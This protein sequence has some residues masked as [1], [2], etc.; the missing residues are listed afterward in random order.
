MRGKFTPHSLPHFNTLSGEIMT[1]SRMKKLLFLVGLWCVPVV[2][3][4]MI[5]PVA[6]AEGS[7]P[8]KAITK[9]VPADA[10]AAVIVSPTKWLNSPM[11]EMFPLEVMRVQMA[12]QVG[13][14]P[15]DIQESK[16]VV[17]LDNATMQPAFGSMTTLA[18]EIDFELVRNAVN[19]RQEMIQVDGY[20]TYPVDGPPGTV[21]AMINEQTLFYGTASLIR[22]MLDAEEETGKLPSLLQTMSGDAA[23][24]IAVVLDQ[25]RPMVSGV[26]MQNANNLAP[27]L[28]PLAQIPGLTDAIKIQI[29]MLEATGSLKVA[30]VGTDEV[31]AQRI[32]SILI[33]SIAAARVLGI[34]EINRSLADS[35]QS[36]AMREATNQYANR[37]ADMV[38]NALQ[39]K[40]NDD[41][42][43]LEAQS[44]ISIATTGVLVGLLLPA[45]QAA[46]TAAR[47]MS[48]S[49]NMKQVM[50]A[51]HNYH[52]AFNRLPP[53]AI[54]DEDGNPLLS[55]RVAILPFIEEQELYEK[56]HLDEPWDSEHN[57]PLSKEL[58]LVYE[59]P[60]APLPAGKTV[61]QAVVG[62]GMGLRPTEETGFRDFRDG[63]SNS[64]MILQ[65]DAD[66]AVI[67]S[68]PDDLEIDM[69]SPLEHLGSAEMGGFHIG[70]ADGSIRFI[71][72]NVDPELFKKMLTRAG[73]EPIQV[74]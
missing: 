21:I 36:E 68:K 49:N 70:M 9:Y 18:G 38:T 34:A 5:K 55:W 27:D 74:P 66:A 46:R 72:E 22:K 7:S 56:F 42:V 4:G 54:S 45:V 40:L 28:Q 3:G 50:L 8:A 44:G 48:M 19:A 59:S 73:K 6:A 35:D 51:M 1:R 69:D 65:V 29:D 63:L 43:S 11:L 17:L 37:I 16:M 20:E 26:A 12:E 60:N 53:A 61:L 39:P 25:V 15:F 64:V 31:A 71:T 13:I 41:E 2:W 62:D 24:K 47:R 52:A 33:D 14:D 10:M 23:V 67:W 30:L 57:L 58:P 32:Q